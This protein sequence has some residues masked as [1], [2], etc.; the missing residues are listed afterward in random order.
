MISLEKLRAEEEMLLFNYYSKAVPLFQAKSGSSSGFGHRSKDQEVQL[1][2][3]TSTS[4]L[5]FLV[6]P[7]AAMFL[8]SI[9]LKGLSYGVDTVPLLVKK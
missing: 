3:G 9:F 6:F 1:S 4:D 8:A 2:V 5:K 7:A